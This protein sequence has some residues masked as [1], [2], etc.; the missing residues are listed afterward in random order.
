[1]RPNSG[2][3]PPLVLLA[4]IPRV[5]HRL[6]HWARERDHFGRK[7]RA[8]TSCPC[9]ASIHE[10]GKGDNEHELHLCARQGPE[11]T[12]KQVR[13]GRG[14][15]PVHLCCLVCI[16]VLGRKERKMGREN[17][18]LEPG[19]HVAPVPGGEYD[20]VEV[21]LPAVREPDPASGYLLHCSHYLAT[22]FHIKTQWSSPRDH[23]V[24]I[25]EAK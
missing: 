6:D 23:V 3:D 24:F 18:Y 16:T 21:L 25:Q 15:T 10:N 9:A 22:L 8:S 12:D 7:Q 11:P 13:F 17:I 1:V 20:C 19:R 5:T 2:L 14:V 4:P